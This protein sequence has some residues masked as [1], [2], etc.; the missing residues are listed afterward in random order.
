MGLSRYV[1]KHSDMK[2]LPKVAGSFNYYDIITNLNGANKPAVAKLLDVDTAK[3]K[4]DLDTTSQQH[5]DRISTTCT[6]MLTD[7]D[8]VAATKSVA[9]GSRKE[10]LARLRTNSSDLQSKILSLQ[11]KRDELAKEIDTLKREQ[12]N[13]IPEILTRVKSASPQQFIDAIKPLKRKLS[14]FKNRYEA[15]KKDERIL[16]DEVKMMREKVLLETRT[17]LPSQT[18]T[19][20]LS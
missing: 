6:N 9:T 12:H 10:E 19:P 4:Q 16:I 2:T 17:H 14:E 3:Y 15:F 18:E 8:K 11:N 5:L 1:F 13:I 20:R 7:L